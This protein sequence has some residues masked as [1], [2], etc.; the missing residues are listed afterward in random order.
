[1]LVIPQSRADSED[2][3]LSFRLILN[4]NS[5]CLSLSPSVPVCVSQPPSCSSLTI[6]KFYVFCPL[7]SQGPNSESGLS[8]HGKEDRSHSKTKVTFI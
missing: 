8:A 6:Q 3:C 2:P 4:E 5:L 7:V 1:M